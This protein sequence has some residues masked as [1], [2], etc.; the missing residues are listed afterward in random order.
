ME[1]F[2]D[3]LERRPHRWHVAN[4]ILITLVLALIDSPS[5]MA[6][7]GALALAVLALFGA[8]AARRAMI[9]AMAGPDDRYVVIGGAV[10]EI[11][12]ALDPE[13]SV[14]G[15][16]SGIPRE[17]RFADVPEIRGFRL[18]SA[19][20]LL[21]LRPSLILIAERQITPELLAQL[22]ATGVRIEVFPTTKDLDEVQ[23]RIARLG[24]LLDREAEA[25][26]LSDTLAQ[27]WAAAL[28]GTAGAAKRPRGLF[29][30]SGGGRG[31]LAGGQDALS[32][33]LIGWA[34]GEN[35][36]CFD[37]HRPL[38]Q[39]ALA[40]LAPDFIMT[41]SEGLMPESG[42]APLL[43]TPGIRLTPAYAKNDIFAVPSGYLT[44]AGLST[45][46]A[47]RFLAGEFD[48]IRAQE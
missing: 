16:G 2:F 5:L 45:P 35:L 21:A 22:E 11:F 4:V 19:E 27:D 18:T 7:V 13:G 8:V 20:N 38:A 23:A 9:G 15:A 6:F 17:G 44:E 25:A 31:N 41:N 33:L 28:A 34:G 48:R 32:A 30:L 37:G 14:V 36:T 42:E 47:I 39:E 26:E 12:E 46:A 24:Q 40:A 43:S 10:G 29:I 1:A 3:W